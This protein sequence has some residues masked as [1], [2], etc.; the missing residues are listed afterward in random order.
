L[1]ES[2]GAIFE[3]GPLSGE[4]AERVETI[5]KNVEQDAPVDNYHNFM[6]GSG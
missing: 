2:L 5:W 1:D 4:I 6:K 3:D